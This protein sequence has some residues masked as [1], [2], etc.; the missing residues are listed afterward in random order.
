MLFIIKYICRF[1]YICIY[2]K[3]CSFEAYLLQI[4]KVKQYMWKTRA[5]VTAAMIWLSLSREE[6]TTIFVFVFKCA[7]CLAYL[8]SFIFLGMN[9][10]VNTKPKFSFGWILLSDSSGYLDPGCLE[11]VLGWAAETH[12]LCLWSRRTE[13]GAALQIFGGVWRAAGTGRYYFVQK[14]NSSALLKKKGHNLK[15]F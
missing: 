2:H 13:M 11:M 6:F 9:R 12:L 5:W 14:M 7:S 10:Y 3:L 1:I 8:G 4:T 15:V